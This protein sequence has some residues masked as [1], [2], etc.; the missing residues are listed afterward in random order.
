MRKLS[1]KPSL[2]APLRPP[3]VPP[4]FGGEVGEGSR[5]RLKYDQTMAIAI[6]TVLPAPVAILKA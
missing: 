3:S 5:R 6:T 2:P 4:N 1:A